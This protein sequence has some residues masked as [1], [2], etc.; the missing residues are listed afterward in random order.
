MEDGLHA[1][2]SRKLGRLSPAAP[3]NYRPPVSAARLW[4]GPPQSNLEIRRR[5]QPPTFLA[6]GPRFV[7][8]SLPV[9]C[10][11]GW[12][13]SLYLLWTLFLLSLHPLLLRPSGMR[14]RRLGPLA[15]RSSALSDSEAEGPGEPP[16]LSWR[17]ATICDVI[18]VCCSG[19]Q[20]AFPPSNRKQTRVVTQAGLRCRGARGRR[21]PRRTEDPGPPGRGRLRWWPPGWELRGLFP[22]QE[23]TE[24]WVLCEIS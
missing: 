18:N 5:P 22:F 24:I 10:G 7:A 2:A 15:Q 14:A 16:Q 17:A 23:D 3:R 9:D 21:G 6:P 8:D 12:F 4:E 13:K 11:E 1:P 19:A 20:V